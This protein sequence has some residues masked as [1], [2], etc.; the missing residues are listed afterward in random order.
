MS[1]FKADGLGQSGPETN[2]GA[3]KPTPPA[4]KQ[5]RA[6]AGAPKV[7]QSW[8]LKEAGKLSE[9]EYWDVVRIISENATRD[10]KVKLAQQVCGQI[11]AT[12]AFANARENRLLGALQKSGSSNLPT[13]DFDR[14]P[15]KER[16]KA[17]PE[18]QTLKNSSE[19]KLFVQ[20]EKEL[21]EL[22][23]KLGI[24]KNDKSDPRVAA[25]AAGFENARKADLD[26]RAKTK[27]G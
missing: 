5:P 27:T 20:T 23:A 19:Y 7:R 25:A 11:N 9:D 24:P 17:K 6:P 1:D 10:Q 18:N 26:L 16:P 13:V 15:K 12:V 4:V 22:K 3:G 14:N 8:T 21:R 2:G